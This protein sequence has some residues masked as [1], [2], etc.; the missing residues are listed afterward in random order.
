[1]EG[2]SVTLEAQGRSSQ[3]DALAF[4]W[5]LDGDGEFETPGQR[6]TFS[7]TGLEAPGTRSVTVRVTGGLG[8]SSADTAVVS[9]IWNFTGFLRPVDNPPVR[10]RANAGSAIPL[11][12][13]LSGNQG[14][15]ILAAGYPR[16]SASHCD[17]SSVEDLVEETVASQS[18][19]VYDASG[20]RYVFVWKT[21]KQWAGSSAR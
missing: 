12:F 5:D 8:L 17:V 15:D 9:V 10:N 3:T 11:K 20:D 2:G 13:S 6:V 21:D 18:A 7:A 4:D 14:L 16:S 19:L 1:M